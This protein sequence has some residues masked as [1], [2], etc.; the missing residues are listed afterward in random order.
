MAS[1]CLTALNSALLK[2]VRGRRR[3]PSRTALS[4]CVSPL[5]NTAPKHD[6]ELHLLQDS[7]F[8]DR[9]LD[10]SNIDAF[11]SSPL[12]NPRALV[13]RDVILLH[14][15]IAFFNLSHNYFKEHFLS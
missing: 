1:I 7:S 12:N 6:K 15:F 9:S 4:P 3:I 13:K 5:W 2:P 8:T 10:Y 14:F 11:L